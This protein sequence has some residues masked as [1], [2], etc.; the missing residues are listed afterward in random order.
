[1]T[2]PDP[3]PIEIPISGEELPKI[4]SP[5]F[6]IDLE[7]LDR[8]LS[9]LC[10]V[11]EQSGARILLALKGFACWPLFERIAQTLV[12]VTCSSIDEARLGREEFKREVHGYAP[13]YSDDNIDQWLN[14]VDHLS[15]NSFSQWKRFGPKLKAVSD[16]VHAGIRVNP[17]HSEVKTAL[18]DPC[19]PGSR[20]GVPPEAFE[21]DAL[22]GITGLHFHTLCELNSDSLERTLGAFEGSFGKYF[23]R[24][25]W[26]NFG[27]GHHITRPDYDV[28]RLIRLILRF[29]A[30]HGHPTVYLEPGEAVA[31]NTGI[32][33]ATVLDLMHN[34]VD[35][36]ILDTSASA[37]MPDVL[38]MPY[39]PVI[40]GA[41]LPGRKP[42][43]YR[44]GGMT[45][46]AGDVIG[47]YSFDHPLKVGDRLIFGDM[48][49][50]SMVKTTTFN[51]VRLPSIATFTRSSRSVDLLRTFGYEDYKHRLG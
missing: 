12:G 40:E 47:D 30:R 28:D 17:K 6:V 9:I 31:L 8:N 38:E 42:H 20:L 4:P 27:G 46:L 3:R 29:R 1:M 16:K 22:D 10:H 19:A 5:C 2:T 14:L 49:H 50:Y 33:V 45:C 7:A 36:A 23:S 34:D 37:H 51:G 35:I 15:F 24:M 43:T 48:A 39:R 13:A 44:L 25:K 26:F 18:Y 11:Q 21:A 32:L 41:D